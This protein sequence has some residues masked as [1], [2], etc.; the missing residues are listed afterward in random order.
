VLYIGYTLYERFGLG[1]RQ[2]CVPLLEVDFESDVVW[3]PGEGA[4]IQDE[5]QYDGKNEEDATVP[6]TPRWRTWLFSVVKRVY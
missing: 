2:H 6:R 1:I 3:K 5:D 4:V